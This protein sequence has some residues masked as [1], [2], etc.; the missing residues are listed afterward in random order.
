MSAGLLV[1]SL[2]VG[3]L[4][5]VVGFT[6][7]RFCALRG[8]PTRLGWSF[9]MAGLLGLLLYGATWR[10]EV[11]APRGIALPATSA[12][13][14]AVTVRTD[15]GVGAAARRVA[16]TLDAAVRE[17]AAAV[18]RRLPANSGQLL[19]LLWLAASGL[20]LAVLVIVG[21]RLMQ[22][23]RRWPV[24]ELHGERVRLAPSI[25]P[26]VIGIVRPEIVVPRWLLG[27][28]DDE[29]RL[30][31]AHEGEHLRARD[32]LLL[33][34]GCVALAVVPW[35]PAAWFMLARLRLAIEM[36]C[37]ARVLRRG[38]SPRPYGTLLIDLAGQCSG[39]RVGAPALA[40]NR[41]HLKRRLIAMTPRTSSNS[42]FRAGLFAA[43][44]GLAVLVACEA[45]IPTAAEVEQMDVAKAEKS[46]ASQWLLGEKVGYAVDGRK[47]TAEEAHAVATS[48]IGSVSVMKSRRPGGE[49]LVSVMTLGPDSLVRD[50]HVA[51]AGDSIHSEASAGDSLQRAGAARQG[52]GMQRTRVFPGLIMIDG[53]VSEQSAMDKLDPSRIES[54]SVVK[55]AA[56]AESSDPRAASGIIKVT[57]KK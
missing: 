2:V 38:V 5:C 49:S 39:F 51:L 33:G 36:D 32:Q 57:T 52:Y 26:A 9:A 41:S 31:L 43:L 15:E 53:V 50:R 7:E 40:E 11:P 47:V 24:T 18:A 25:G 55:G 12:A 22:A 54:V 29:Q 28:S 17:V 21:R 37:D 34:A 6:L 20:A 3:A 48:R 45:K 27:R 46:A 44:A 4:L 16:A 13:A 1:Y 23:R 8:W 14:V 19:A 35:H 56:A 30:V 42:T 10:A